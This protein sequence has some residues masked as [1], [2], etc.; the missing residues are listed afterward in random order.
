MSRYTDDDMFKDRTSSEQKLRRAERA[1]KKSTSTEKARRAAKA[2][3][4]RNLWIFRFA[5]IALIGG[6]FIFT[7]SNIKTIFDLKEETR[8]TEQT[9]AAKEH[10]KQKL[11]QELEIVESD[12]Y[13]E[14]QARAELRMIYNGETLYVTKEDKSVSED[15]GAKSITPAAE[16]G[17]V[18]PK[19][20][21]KVPDQPAEASVTKDK[22]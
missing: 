14:Q 1:V 4:E 5:V 7:G 16:E 21:D 2:R 15:T 20:A 10:Q 17:E 19:D 9:L 8:I 11:E 13:V 3:R 18:S 22:N 6:A 12:E